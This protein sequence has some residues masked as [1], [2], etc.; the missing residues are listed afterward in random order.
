MRGCYSFAGGC[1][2]SKS[3]MEIKPSKDRVI[4]FR[5]NEIDHFSTLS[6]CSSGLS[7]LGLFRR[8]ERRTGAKGRLGK[9]HRVRTPPDRQLWL[10]LMPYHSRDTGRRLDGRASPKLFL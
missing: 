1:L 3:R 8:S 5:P 7:P 6:W 10:R 9:K 2:P 4:I